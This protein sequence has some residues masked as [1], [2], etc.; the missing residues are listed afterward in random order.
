M[1]GS[2]DIMELGFDYN[3]TKSDA[4]KVRAELKATYDVAKQ[5][6]GLKIKIQLADGFT[7][8][9]KAADGL[10][11]TIDELVKKQK[12]LAD[13]QLK[14]AQAAKNLA[15]ANKA[16]ADT[17][18]AEQKAATEMEKTRRAQIQADAE[19]A[20]EKERL[21]KAIERE[22]A[23]T[24]KA[25]SDYALLSAEYLKAKKAVQDLGAAILKSGGS[26]SEERF[27]SAAKGVKALGDNL[28]QIDSALGDDRR[29]V[30]NYKSAFDGL[31][32]SFTQLARELPSLGININTFLL[33]IS[34]NLPMLFDELVK[35]RAEI[36]A[37][38]AAG[39]ET[40]SMFKKVLS[41]ALSLQ[42]GL[43]IGVTL[44]TLYGGKLISLI[45]SLFDTTAAMEKQ[46]KQAALLRERYK[47]LIVVYDDLTQ[48]ANRSRNAESNALANQ[49]TYANALNKSKA[50][51]LE[52]ERK[53]AYDRAAN[54]QTD[55]FG[56]GGFGGLKD[57]QTAYSSAVQAYN[58]LITLQTDYNNKRYDLSD[59]DDK[60]EY[61]RR[62]ADQKDKLELAKSEYEKQ[63]GL[64][65]EYSN[66]IRDNNAKANEITAY[67]EAEKRKLILA[68]IKTQQKSVQDENSRTLSNERSNYDERL[69]AL[70]SN[71]ESQKKV[72]AAERDNI[73]NDPSTSKAERIIAVQSANAAIIEVQKQFYDAEEKLNKEKADRKAQAQLTINQTALDTEE[74]FNEDIYQKESNSLKQRL[75]AYYKYAEYQ[76]DILENEYKYEL[77][78]LKSRFS[79]TE[80]YAA[81]EA[82]THAKRVQLAATTQAEIRRIIEENNQRLQAEAKSVNDA[83]DR[84]L[85]AT[86]QGNVDEAQAYAEAAQMLADNLNKNL[87]TVEEYNKQKLKLDNDY[88]EKSAKD[89]LDKLKALSEERKRR[90]EDTKD[91]DKQIAEAEAKLSD[92]TTKHVIGNEE[93]KRQALIRTFDTIS[94]ITN[95]I[96]DA[97]SALNDIGYENTKTKL[98]E[99]EDQQQQNYENDVTRITNSTLSEVDKANQLK[100]LDST[101]D[102]QKQQFDRKQREADNKKAQFDKQLAIANII[103]DT[104]RA[105]VAALTSTPPN[106]PLSIAVGFVG[107]A[108]LARAIAVKV[109]QY[110]T[111]TD[112]HPGG[113]AIYGEAGPEIVHEPGKVPHLVTAPTFDPSLQRGAKVI[114]LSSDVINDAMYS[115]MLGNTARSLS[116]GEAAGKMSGNRDILNM[117]TWQ[118]RRLE[119]AYKSQSTSITVNI[120]DRS[121]W[122][123]FIDKNVGGK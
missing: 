69:D 55:F 118:T 6:D 28:K 121:R 92:D 93:K 64:Q 72:I 27:T 74:R 53:I 1:A 110:A 108:N 54:A 19:A 70:K 34:N 109:P 48:I 57:K 106:V 16:S 61:D 4:E 58:N 83:F 45:G 102:A 98:Q 117:I 71:L 42:V 122:N 107:A 49:L 104:A 37:L 105:V 30:G 56:A 29:N 22:S 17:T 50:E 35:T 21:A 77:G 63:L 31:S 43:S 113:P 119:K 59:D 115:A 11:F 51:Q 90:G 5:L 2:K 81:L 39:E 84:F 103:V 86:T 41:S 75:S 94:S 32:F 97:V 38:R 62:K 112:S 66:S 40:P 15:A 7:D 14:A 47:E 52:I 44:L 60:K 25:K 33:A 89:Q 76:K 12:D 46:E 20:K 85:Q 100:I 111:G 87:I 73:V 3:L 82:Q 123:T 99:I 67:Y 8:L 78:I 13:I 23:L 24:A 36:T 65:I 96:T 80:E 101:R 9:K 91:L 120:S 18:I 26:L 10:G 79:T 88:A 68:S 95:N 114:P 116:L